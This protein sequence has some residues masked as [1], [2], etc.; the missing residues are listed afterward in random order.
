MNRLANE[1]AAYLRHS[2]YQE[3][4]W[5]PW[6]DEAFE[7]AKKEDK[8][9]LLSSG[10]VWCHWCHVMARECFENREIIE[11]LNRDFICIKLDRDE[12]PDID[13]RFQQLV[14]AIT[15]S[16]GW[17]LTVFLTP[18]GSPF[19]GGTYFPPEEVMGRPGFRKVLITISS[20][21]KNRK[22]TVEAYTQELMATLRQTSFPGGEISKGLLDEGTQAILAEFDPQNGGFGRAPKFPMPGAMELLINR[23][24]LTGEEEVAAAV[25]KTLTAMAKGGF[26]DQVGGGFHR[27]ATDEAWIIPHFEK[28]TDDNAWLLRNY[29]DAYMATGDQAFKET[30]EGIIVFFREVLTDPEG[31]F[32]ASQ[33]ADLTPE[34]EGGYFTWK[35]EEL[36]ELLTDEEYQVIAL[37]LFHEKGAMH[38][39]KAKRV[40]FVSREI[41]EIAKMTAREEAIVRELIRSGKEK[42]LRARA[43]RE[44]PFIDRTLY[45]SLNG[46]AI[47]AFFRACRSFGD[48]ELREFGLKSLDRIL[49][50][51]TTESAILHAPGVQGLLDDYIYLTEAC[52]AA[53]EATGILRFKEK[54]EEIMGLSMVK[55]LDQERGGFFD[56]EGNVLGVRIKAIEDIP[57]PSSNSLAVILLC[58]LFHLTG[59][60]AYLREAEK[61]LQAFS[62]RVR[63]I[64]LAAGQYLVAVETFFRMLRLAVYS[65][66]E[67]SLADAARAFPYPYLTVAY[68]EDRGYILPCLKSECYEPLYSPEELKGF[69]RKALE[70]GR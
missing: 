1:R 34:D 50:E 67:G 46:M 48:D 65:A 23:Y 69:L 7:K 49:L 29:T 13:R 58:K 53:Y 36:K 31:G 45:T 16:G 19:F 60:E 32:Y 15:G 14:A 2:A 63:G 35:V 57:H 55:F 17:P 27:Y 47:S 68:E 62:Q 30:A 28:M 11:I 10:A 39:N 56:T 44:P 25:T 18:E 61:T 64:G 12:R 6:S 54:A 24:A 9:V 52:I 42:L 5:Y 51:H 21:Y 41:P 37:H 43:L 20:F 38:H 40:L 66:P 26:H 59:K 4:D 33:D 70:R 22:S 3:I 8:P